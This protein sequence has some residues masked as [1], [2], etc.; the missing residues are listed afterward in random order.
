MDCD[1][2][3]EDVI[4]QSS[5]FFKK[6][7]RLEKNVNKTQIELLNIALEYIKK[8]DGEKNAIAKIWALKLTKMKPNQRIWAEKFINDILTEGELGTLHRHYVYNQNF[9]T[10]SSSTPSVK[11]PAT[12]D[13]EIFDQPPTILSIDVKEEPEF[14]ERNSQ[15]DDEI[16][17][18][19]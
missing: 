16:Y 7:K 14:Y 2:F 9:P 11:D 19:D 15:I 17:P 12:E 18:R 8:N 10:T 5:N 1:G 6:R 13:P 3:E 4:V